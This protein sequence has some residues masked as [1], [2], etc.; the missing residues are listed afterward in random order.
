MLHLHDANRKYVTCNQNWQLYYGHK[1]YTPC[2][3]E[4]KPVQWKQG[5]TPICNGNRNTMTKMQLKVTVITFALPQLGK[6]SRLVA[7]PLSYRISPTLQQFFHPPPP[8]LGF[9]VRSVPSPLKK[10]EEGN[11]PFEVAYFRVSNN[12]T[13]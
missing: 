12:S 13:S 9:L 10:G 2:K 7:C 4:L 1:K 11:W 6:I 5:L 3:H 8:F